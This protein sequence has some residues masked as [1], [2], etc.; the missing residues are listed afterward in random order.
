MKTLVLVVFLISVLAL[1]VFAYDWVTNPANGHNYTLTSTWNLNWFGAEA[2]AITLG[3]HLAT[4]RNTQEDQWIKNTYGTNWWWIGLND[5]NTEGLFVWSSGE[6]VTYVNWNTSEPNNQNDE[7]FVGMNIGDER[8][9]N[10]FPDGY[11][12]YGVIEV[13]P[14]PEPSSLVVLGALLT[15]LLFRRRR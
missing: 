15:P 4:I 3:G 2:E 7:D 13:V 8:G 10:D 5:V 12:L 6:P 14:V 1:P 11:Q 9:W